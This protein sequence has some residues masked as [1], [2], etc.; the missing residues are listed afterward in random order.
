MGL[1]TV[2]NKVNKLINNVN[3]CLKLL[4]RW[5]KTKEVNQW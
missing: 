3:I 2:L 1:E 4:K 5:Q